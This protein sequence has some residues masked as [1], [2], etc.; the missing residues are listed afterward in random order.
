[1]LFLDLLYGR[2][3]EDNCFSSLCCRYSVTKDGLI[4]TIG[5]QQ[6]SGIIPVSCLH[7]Q[8]TQDFF[9]N[10]VVFYYFNGMFWRSKVP[11]SNLNRNTEHN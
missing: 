2:L 11:S 10:K 5:E 1:M 3:L 7:V 9:K 4:I 8:V 6:S